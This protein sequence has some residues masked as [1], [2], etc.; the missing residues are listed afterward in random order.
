MYIFTPV[1]ILFLCG[2][3]AISICYFYPHKWVCCIL[4][5]QWQSA[6]AFPQRLIAS[7][8]LC[9]RPS[10]AE[11][12]IRSLSFESGSSRWQFEHYCNSS[13]LTKYF[14]VKWHWNV[15]KYFIAADCFISAIPCG[16]AQGVRLFACKLCRVK[17][18]Q[19][20]TSTYGTVKLPKIWV[21]I[22]HYLYERCMVKNQA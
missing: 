3:A 16:S 2:A 12:G 8:L 21:W 19:T 18:K 17:L 10:C 6:E 14:L 4:H 7:S 15:F 22:S 1:W 5:S 20:S 9:I 13:R 11:P